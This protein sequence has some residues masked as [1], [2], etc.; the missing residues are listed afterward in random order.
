M[1]SIVIFL[2]MAQLIEFYIIKQKG[3]AKIYYFC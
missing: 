3:R 1:V 2:K